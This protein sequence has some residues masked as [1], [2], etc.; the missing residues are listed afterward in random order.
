M[1][2]SLEPMGTGE[3]VL[4]RTPSAYAL[5]S[6]ID[7]WDFRKLQS[8]FK[9]KDIVRT[10]W[11][12][13]DWEKIFINPTSNRGLI[14]NICKTLEKLNSRE[15]NNTIKK[16]GRDSQRILKW[17]P[18][19]GCEAPKELI[20]DYESQKILGRCHTDR[21]RTQMPDKLSAKLSI[22]IDEETKIFHDKIKFTQCI[23][24]N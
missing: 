5:R 13:T 9:A 15:P 2:K 24:K 22:N 6:S 20:R 1:R 14:S 10:K 16:W 23:S 21:K 4:N 19:N 12:P 18:L 8:F 3:N 11:Q 17:G 7:K